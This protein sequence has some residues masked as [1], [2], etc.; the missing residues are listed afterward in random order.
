[1]LFN[2]HR[3]EN[4]VIKYIGLVIAL[5]VH[6]V[7]YSL[8]ATVTKA[9]QPVLTTDPKQ[10]PLFSVFDTIFTNVIVFTLGQM[11]VSQILLPKYDEK[12]QI[13]FYKEF[14]TI[15]IVVSVV[16]TIFAV[17]GIAEKD[18][19]IYFGL[20]D[21]TVETKGLKDYWGILKGNKPFVLLISASALAKFGSM[22]FQDA[23]IV[24]MLY[25]IVLGSYGLS[26][27]V[28]GYMLVPQ[29]LIIFGLSYIAGRKGQRFTYLTSTI[30]TSIAL[31]LLGA[32]LMTSNTL[33]IAGSG[34]WPIFVIIILAVRIFAGYPST[35]S[36]T[37]TADV[38]EYET[39]RSG[40]YVSG[41]MGTM[42]SLTDS[43]ASSLTPIVVNWVV[44]SIGFRES[45][46]TID[47]PYSNNIFTGVMIIFILIPLVLYIIITLLISR[48]PL[49]AKAMEQTSRVIDLKIQGIIP[50]DADG[51]KYAKDHNIDLDRAV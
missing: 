39:A 46:P 40:R 3:I 10:R 20:G 4:Q 5:V 16:F 37:M 6:K 43:I 34:K 14:V 9:A 25:G 11:F 47:T 28:A 18:N 44:A 1:M 41:M 17:I 8:Q 51:F 15:I 35:V 48:Y 50:D 30:I 13:S 27:T 22:L 23:T 31:A 49:N 26:G 19:E 21:T 33:E 42:F 12:F 7:G 32:L 45:L 36:L 2:T 38:S 24:V 29:I